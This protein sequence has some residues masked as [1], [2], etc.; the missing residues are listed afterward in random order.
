MSSENA[1]T[2]GFVFS[3]FW[4]RLNMLKTYQSQIIYLKSNNRAY[5]NHYKQMRTRGAIVF[6]PLAKVQVTDCEAFM[7]NLTTFR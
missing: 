4:G 6:D 5:D 7:Q 2:V 1:H 3:L